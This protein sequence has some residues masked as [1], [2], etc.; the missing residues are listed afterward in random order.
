MLLCLL[1]AH[2]PTLAASQGL[3]RSSDTA[4][5]SHPECSHHDRFSSLIHV[6]AQVHL[7]REAF[8]VNP[9]HSLSSFPALF[10]FIT[11]ITNL[12][13]EIFHLFTLLFI[14]LLILEA[15]STRGQRFSS[16]TVTVV[17][18]SKRVSGTE[19]VLNEYLLLNVWTQL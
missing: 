17:S 2:L 4:G 14:C 13:S 8:P 1:L 5:H 3:L 6:F 12:I 7:L 16:V 9:L 19:Q 18:P 10:F 15:P 11:L